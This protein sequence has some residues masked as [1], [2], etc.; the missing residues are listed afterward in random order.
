M[1][2]SQKQS[3]TPSGVEKVEVVSD[4]IV[5]TENI[6]E[7]DVV[8]ELELSVGDAYNGGIIFTIDPSN[9]IGK[10]AYIEDKGPMTWKNAM[11]IHEQLGEGWRLPELDELRGLYK[12][13]G[14]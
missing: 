13:I 14:P 10:I 5:K 3:F 11:S 7:I 9:K 12:T 1:W 2:D 4:A 6:E 8:A